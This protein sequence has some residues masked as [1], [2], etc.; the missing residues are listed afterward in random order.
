VNQGRDPELS[1]RL[2]AEILVA[3]LAQ[4]SVER[5]DLPSLVKELREALEVGPQHWIDARDQGVETPVGDSGEP[6]AKAAGAPPQ[7]PPVPA[8]PVRETITDDYLV[9]LEDGK[10]YRTLKRHLMV[11]YGMTPE[12]YRRKWGLP[13]DY[14]MVAP[15]YARERSE[16]AKRIG[17]GRAEVKPAQDKRRRAT[18]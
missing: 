7:E 6:R 8:V 9:S 16:V 18:T 4:H 15:S 10:P 11:K 13:S 14:P 3:Y 17:L 5:A 2:A 12:Q 1:S